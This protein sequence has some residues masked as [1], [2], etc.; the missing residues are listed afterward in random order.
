MR[1]LRLRCFVLLRGI[2][3][4]EL[5]PAAERSRR[6]RWRGPQL[7]PQ[8]TDRAAQKLFVELGQLAR[9]DYV[10]RGAEDGCDVGERFQDAVRGFIEDMGCVA[11]ASSSSAVLRW[12]AFAGRKPWKV[13]GRLGDRSQ[14]AR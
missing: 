13:N 11:A 3:R 14:S 9:D 6:G 7:G 5:A 2:S 4:S 12:P 8:F 10:L 1:L